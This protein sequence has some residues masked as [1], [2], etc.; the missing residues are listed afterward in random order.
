MWLDRERTP[1]GGPAVGEE[2]IVHTV[3]TKDVDCTGTLLLLSR[4]FCSRKTP[5]VVKILLGANC[6]PKTQFGSL[7][8]F[9]DPHYVTLSN[10]T[11]QH[12]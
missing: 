10:K 12:I 1:P 6:L 5:H 4:D 11:P 3:D 2:N 7:D 9:P 8:T